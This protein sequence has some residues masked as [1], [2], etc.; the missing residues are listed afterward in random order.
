MISERCPKKDTGIYKMS[1]H[2]LTIF[3]KLPRSQKN[4][5]KEKWK[6]VFHFSHNVLPKPCPRSHTFSNKASLLSEWSGCCPGVAAGEAAAMRGPKK[7][8]GARQPHSYQLLP[9]NTTLY[10]R[11]LHSQL[12]APLQMLQQCYLLMSACRLGLPNFRFPGLWNT[13]HKFIWGGGGVRGA[14]P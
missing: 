9:A 7:L 8:E 12:S 4:S 13:V 10:F 3:Q 11:E 6:Y 1:S 5:V 14:P 2:I